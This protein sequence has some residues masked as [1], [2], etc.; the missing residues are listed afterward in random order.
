MDL[1]RLITMLVRMFARKGINA[2]ITYAA[3]RGK[4]P[5]TMTPEEQQQAKA[6]RQTAKRARQALKLGRRIGRL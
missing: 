4:D 5:K 3:N 1:N 6:A 2:G